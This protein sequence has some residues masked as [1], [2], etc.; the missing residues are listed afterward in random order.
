M[1]ALTP[2]RVAADHF[3]IPISTL[4]YWERRGLLAPHRRPGGH[5]CYDADQLYRIALIQLWRDTGTMSIDEISEVLTG[6]STE[7]EWRATVGARVAT[8][9]AQIAKLDTA[10]AY[11]THLLTCPHGADLEQCPDFRARTSVPDG[12][13]RAHQ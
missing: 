1:D 11:L 7:D 6:Q 12:A 3:R 8:I 4:H 13:G 2:I 5:R 10:M 9:R